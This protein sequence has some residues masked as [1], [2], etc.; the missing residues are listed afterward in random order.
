MIAQSG[1]AGRAMPDRGY[2]HR[3]N[4]WSAAQPARSISVVAGN[5]SLATPSNTKAG[6]T[7]ASGATAIPSP[8]ASTALR[9][10]RRKALP[11]RRANS[12]GGR[13]A[14]FPKAAILP[15]PRATAISACRAH[16]LSRWFYH[17]HALS[18]LSLLCFYGSTFPGF[19]MFCG[20]NACLILRCTSRA[21][22]PSACSM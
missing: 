14:C 18:R 15:L 1:E 20:S 22:P 6:A 8:I 3:K 11:R 19:K 5:E 13:R 4:T 7:S 16:A 17:H 9:L 2:R 21:I 10:S 12:E